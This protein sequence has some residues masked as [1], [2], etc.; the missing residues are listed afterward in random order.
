MQR[1]D[2][3]RGRSIGVEGRLSLGEGGAPYLWK[4]GA[5]DLFLKELRRLRTGLDSKLRTSRAIIFS[6]GQ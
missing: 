1:G 4:K 2:L 5:V 6:P 3:R